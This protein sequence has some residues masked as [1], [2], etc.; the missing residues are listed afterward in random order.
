MLENR[1]EDMEVC[2]LS[3]IKKLFPGRIFFKYIT[4]KKRVLCQINLVK[5]LRQ[6]KS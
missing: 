3:V 6:I 1:N 2:Y 4:V 5:I